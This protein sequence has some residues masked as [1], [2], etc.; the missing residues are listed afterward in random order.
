MPGPRGG[1]EDPDELDEEERGESGGRPLV[2]TDGADGQLPRHPRLETPSQM[3]RR[4]TTTGPPRPRTA[5]C[6]AVAGE[7]VGGDLEVV[8]GDMEDVARPSLIEH[9]E[10]QCKNSE[11]WQHF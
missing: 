5:A 10:Y 4:R 1:E 7:E 8:A 3:R 2:R 9:Q 6:L 11:C